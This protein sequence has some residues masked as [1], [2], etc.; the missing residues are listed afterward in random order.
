MRNVQVKFWSSEFIKVN[1]H[2]TKGNFLIKVFSE[3]SSTRNENGQ[4]HSGYSTSQ[5][6]KSLRCSVQTIKNIL[7]YMSFSNGTKDHQFAGRGNITMYRNF[8]NWVIAVEKLWSSPQRWSRWWK[9]TMLA[10]NYWYP[11]E[12]LICWWNV[13]FLV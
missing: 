2:F 5:N 9:K 6:E 8:G 10:N 4:W 13:F 1:F 11:W 12:N 3:N 7:N